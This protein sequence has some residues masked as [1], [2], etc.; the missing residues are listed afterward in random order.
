MLKLNSVTFKDDETEKIIEVHLSDGNVT[1]N[2]PFTADEYTTCSFHAGLL[3]AGG[4][5]EIKKLS[6][7]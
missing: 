7:K 6:K 3:L 1:S 5:S 2:Q 4:I